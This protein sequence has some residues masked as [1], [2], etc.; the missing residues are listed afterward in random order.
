M[1]HFEKFESNFDKMI[2]TMEYT[3]QTSNEALDQLIDVS[4]QW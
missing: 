4:I 3:K 2:A 1:F